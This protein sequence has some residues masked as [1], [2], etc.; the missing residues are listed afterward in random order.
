M[1]KS[2]LFWLILLA[3]LIG[4]GAVYFSSSGSASLLWEISDGGRWLLPL[5]TVAALVDS[6]NPCAISI[7]LLTMAFLFSLGRL[8]SGIL[9]VGGVYILGIF[10]VYLFIGLGILQALH[11][12]GIPH[13]MAKVGATLL[14]AFGAINVLEILIPGFPIRLAIPHFAH[15]TI[16]RLVDR[17]SIPTALLLGVFVGLCEFPCTGGP[18]LAVLGLLH[19]Q[20]TFAAGFGYLL[21]YNVIFV[22]PLV[23]ILLIASNPVILARVQEW[24]KA[25]RKNERFIAG[26]LM[27]ALGIVMFL[28]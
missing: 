8:R 5:L 17:M 23:V 26:I 2:K 20:G 9:A 16:A 27:V 14:I 4:I 3:V 6:I 12:F 25:E 10:L 19:D 28:L 18:Y 7:L 1:I 21:L 22:L 11:V 24:Q 13:F 15:G